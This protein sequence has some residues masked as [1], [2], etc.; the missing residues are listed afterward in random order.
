MTAYSLW[1][2]FAVMC[3]L[4]LLAASPLLSG[5]DEPPSRHG[6][7]ISAL[8]GLR[9]LLALGVFFHHAAVYQGYLLDGQW[10]LP[11]SRFYTLLG[12]CGVAMF[13]MITGFLFWSRLIKRKERTDW[14]SLYVGRLFRIGP[15]YLLA[16]FCALFVVFLKAGFTANVT[17]VQLLGEIGRWLAL[18]YLP[19]T[20]V[21]GYSD[22]PFV[23]AGVTWTLHYE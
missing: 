3:V 17:A 23:L 11:P 13:F 1:P 15:L 21:N 14:V 20:P 22:A 8:D 4:L 2:Y 16:A 9:G 12:Q 5:A 18:G 19:L 10:K 7:R 6:S